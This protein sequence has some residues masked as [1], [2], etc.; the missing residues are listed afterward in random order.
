MYQSM[1]YIQAFSNLKQAYLLN[2]YKYPYVI[3]TCKIGNDVDFDF[4]FL[5][6]VYLDFVFP[7]HL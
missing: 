7:Q 2:N 3:E 4:V 6:Y 1:S 5:Q